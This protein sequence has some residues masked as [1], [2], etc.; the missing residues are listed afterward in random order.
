MWQVVASRQWK[1]QVI[2]VKVNHVKVMCHREHFFE[3]EN[4]VSELVYALLV[5]PQGPGAARYQ[6]SC[7][8][9][10]SAGE[11]SNVVPLVHQLLGE[12]RNDSFSA[13]VELR[14]NALVKW[15]HLCDFQG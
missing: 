9:G 15:G 3:H 11:K 12:V 10:V 4:M 14:R 5:E 6:S 1:V 2:D 7:G 8:F 13:T